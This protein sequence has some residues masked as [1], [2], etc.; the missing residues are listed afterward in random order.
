MWLN[1]DDGRRMSKRASFRNANAYLSAPYG[2]Y[3]ARD[4]YLAITITPIGRLRDLL[5][6]DTL[7]PY[8][9]TRRTLEGAW[10]RPRH[11]GY[12]PF[13]EQA[14]RIVNDAVSGDI[15]FELAID[16]PERRLPEELRG[17]IAPASAN[18]PDFDP[19]SCLTAA[20][21]FSWRWRRT[22]FPCPRG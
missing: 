12:M 9:A 2:V 4:G 17:L 15:S 22:P 1:G 14:S 10:L 3:P 16:P 5:G 7:S 13:R 21:I 8:R 6:L 19:A 11:N 20:A 18:L